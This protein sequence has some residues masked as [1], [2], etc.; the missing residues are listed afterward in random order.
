MVDAV[1]GLCTRPVDQPADRIDE[2]VAAQLGAVDITVLRVCPDRHVGL[3]DD[4]ADPQVA[5]AYLRTLV[6]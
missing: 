2:C 6:S 4:T 5:E 1:I 3:R